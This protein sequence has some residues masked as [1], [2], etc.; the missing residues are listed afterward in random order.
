MCKKYDFWA[1]FRRMIL[2]ILSINPKFLKLETEK[3]VRSTTKTVLGI[4][5]KYKQKQTFFGARCFF[6]EPVLQKLT[7]L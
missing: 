7:V 1:N 4:A 3:D 2:T 6:G 5:K